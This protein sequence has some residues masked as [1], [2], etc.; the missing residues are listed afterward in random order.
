[1]YSIEPFVHKTPEELPKDYLT[2]FQS[3]PKNSPLKGS[4]LYLGPVISLPLVMKQEIAKQPFK[5]RPLYSE[6]GLVLDDICNAVAQGKPYSEPPQAIS[7]RAME[8]RIKQREKEVQEW[9]ESERKRKE[10]QQFLHE[11]LKVL[12]KEKEEQEKKQQEE[13]QKPPPN[14]KELEW[15]RYHEEQK[16]KIKEYKEKVAAEKEALEEK[17]KEKKWKER[18][19]KK[20]RFQDFN[21]KKIGELVT[22]IFYIIHLSCC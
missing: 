11:R 13:K 10:R 15:I 3:D 21:S 16:G 17:E 6:V 14:K 7:N 18:E 5:H 20:R 12:A 4:P 1:M 22:K 8:D 2:R 19:I 9:Q